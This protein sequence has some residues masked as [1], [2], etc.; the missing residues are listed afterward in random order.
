MARAALSADETHVQTTMPAPETGSTAA[1][2]GD[3]ESIVYTGLTR[4]SEDPLKI[5]VMWPVYPVAAATKDNRYTTGPL[6]YSF[7]LTTAQL[8][9]PK[10]VS[11]TTLLNS[12]WQPYANIS[13]PVEHEGAKRLLCS[14][15]Q[16]D[17]ATRWGITCP[18]QGKPALDLKDKVV[19]IG[20]ESP[21]DYP[22]VPGGKMY[23][24][25]LQAH[26]IAALIAG[27]YLR[28][29]SPW[30]IFVVL[31]AYY[32]IAEGLL[33]HLSV[34]EHPVLGLPH[35]KAAWLWE[36]GLFVLTLLVG[37][38]V[39]LWRHRFPP[40]GVMLIVVAIFVPRLLI[41]LWTLINERMDEAEKEKE[42]S[43]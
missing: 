3:K 42:R 26:Y 36:V 37:F 12:K 4:L 7:A 9:N 25:D 27:A 40:L 28:D 33:P 1:A 41:E 32:G 29:F 35:V 8:V 19:V 31:L 2:A 22:G 30:W 34:R 43:S 18:K 21:N 15:G 5:P 24:F 13:D 11:D 20:S 39:P 14:A 38:F 23:G 10:I 17:V 6:S 16:T